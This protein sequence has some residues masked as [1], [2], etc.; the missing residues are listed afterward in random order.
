MNKFEIII[1]TLPDRER[2]V[3]EIYYDNMHWVEISEETDE[4]VI[5]FYRHPSMPYWEFDLDEALE[6]LARAKA[7]LL[8]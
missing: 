4:P 8:D 7:K 3:A 5:Q 6:V 1:V 2:P